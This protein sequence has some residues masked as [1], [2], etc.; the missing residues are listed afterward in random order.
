MIG[1][2][3]FAFVAEPV[4]V[5]RFAGNGAPLAPWR[6][7]Q[8]NRKVPPTRY[9]R[10]TV[11]GVQA[12]EARSQ[13]SM[14]LL[15]RPISVDLAATPMLC[16]RWFVEAPVAKA[17]LTKKSG[18]DYAARLYVA[19]DLPDARMSTGTRLKLRLARSLFGRDVPDAALNYVWDNR[20]PVGTS[21]RSAYT[22]RAQLIVAETGSGRA[23]QW[24]TERADIATDFG[25]AFGRA[26]KPIQLAIASDTDNSGGSARAAFAD[27][28]FVN[29]LERCRF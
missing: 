20:H 29:R 4:W 9:R 19:F 21:R 13:R 17:D 2:L 6:V 3:F 25:K 26:A 7:V 23:G 5:G 27:I 1:L 10:A 14:A 24:V 8:I 22:D 11:S 12:I 16:W 18:D 28:H 15:A